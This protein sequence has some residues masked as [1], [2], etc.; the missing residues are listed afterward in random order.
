MIRLTPQKIELEA[1][2]GD[3]PRRTF[4]GIAAPYGVAAT[5]MDGTKVQFAEGA[6]PADGNAPKLLE[7]HDQSR[8]VGIVTERVS[9]PGVGMS[10]A[11]RISDT[12]AG[13]DAL[14]LIKDGVLTEVSVG[15]DPIE[16][17]WQGDTMVVTKAA[18]NEL[19]LVTAGAFGEQAKIET[20]YAQAATDEPASTD[21]E[22]EPT[23]TQEGEPEV[24]TPEVIE[25]AAPATVETTPTV[26]ASAR[27]E[28]KLPSASEYICAMV[29][30]G[31]EFA[32]LNANIRAAAPDVVTGDIPGVLPIPIVQPIYNN[33]RGL[34]PVIDASGARAL[35]SGGKVFIRPVVTT[36][37]SIGGGLAENTTITQSTFVVTDVQIQK[38]IF[39]GF[40]DVSEASIDW[41]QPEVLGAMLDDMGRVYAN[42]TDAAACTELETCTQTE[43]LGTITDP[44]DWAT[45]VYNAAAQILTNSNGN[46]PNT[47]Y[48]DPVYWATVGQLVDQSGRPLFPTV[49]PMNAF[50]DVAPGM[51]AGSAFGLRIVV[52]RN[53]SANT[54]IVGNSEGLECWED[55]R[56][57]IS[58]NQPSTLSRQI[59][60]RGYAA[61]KLIDDTKFVK[62]V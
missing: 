62:A 5:T 57:A 35:P 27:R 21:V 59:A 15:V 6:L 1:A 2:A 20:V 22:G 24:E 10:F 18:W 43:T 16:F 28:F 17:S 50:G 19:S 53:L 14:T 36:H 13:R 47:L 31:S 11:A 39:G 52:D 61:F 4:I 32:Q 51:Y 58:V 60:F 54:A 33:F 45:F 56:G 23:P 30:G 55:L 8:P 48:L 12:A 46:L 40:S 41:S 26:F 38:E 49:A 44:A 7:F 29:R 25:A 42:Q 37:S 3:Q 9:I 34:R